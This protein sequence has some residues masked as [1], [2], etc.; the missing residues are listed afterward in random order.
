[1]LLYKRTDKT[2]ANMFLQT[3]S[4]QTVKRTEPNQTGVWLCTCIIIL[5]SIPVYILCLKNPFPFH[6]ILIVALNTKEV[7]VG[8]SLVKVHKYIHHTLK[9]AYLHIKMVRVAIVR[10]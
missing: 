5:I 1:M 10:H 7:N 9:T 6:I 2:E 3:F 8:P 4:F